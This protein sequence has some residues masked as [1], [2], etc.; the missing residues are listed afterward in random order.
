MVP[1]ATVDIA[2]RAALITCAAEGLAG[3]V[4][5]QFKL[6]WAP[7]EWDALARESGIDGDLLRD[8][9]LAFKNKG[10]PHA[11]RAPGAGAVPDLLGER[12]AVAIGGRILLGGS[13]PAKYKNSPETPIYTKSRR[14]TG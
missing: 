12:D 8:N 10:E 2:R 1:H 13:D 14:C 3:D 4:A 7:D 9:G 6:G 11:G 5:R